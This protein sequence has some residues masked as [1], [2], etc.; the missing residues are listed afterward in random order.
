MGRTGIGIAPLEGYVPSDSDIDT[1]GN[2]TSYYGFVDKEGNWYIQKIT[3]N[4]E[5]I[6]YIK[7]TKINDYATQWA[8]RLALS[9]DYFDVIF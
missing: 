5:S 3:A 4:T 1:T 6:R 8:N 7:G 2:G 9:Y